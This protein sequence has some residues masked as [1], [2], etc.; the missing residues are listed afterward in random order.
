[1]DNT[2]KVN[3][4]LNMTC[5]QTIETLTEVIKIVDTNPNNMV[6]GA[7]IREYISNMGKNE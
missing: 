2:D 7:K 4:I 5:K 6:L 3:E 1:M